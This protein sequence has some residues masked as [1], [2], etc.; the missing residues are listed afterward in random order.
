MIIWTSE[1]MHQAL[2][3]FLNPNA[4]MIPTESWIDTEKNEVCWF[5]ADGPETEKL[6]KIHCMLVK[7]NGDVEFRKKVYSFN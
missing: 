6:D 5:W 3:K 1:K 4:K 7:D 2:W